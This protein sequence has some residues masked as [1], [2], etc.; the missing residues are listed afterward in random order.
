MIASLADWS[1]YDE[2]EKGD[3]EG[4]ACILT[5]MIVIVLWRKKGEK[6]AKVLST[7]K[8]HI[9]LL[10]CV[11]RDCRKESFELSAI[12]GSVATNDTLLLQPAQK[13]IYREYH[14]AFQNI[15]HQ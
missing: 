5:M 7:G 15:R 4:Q 14:H 2:K 8:I 9:L 3:D 12:N 11:A 1:Q 6:R 10:H 13:S